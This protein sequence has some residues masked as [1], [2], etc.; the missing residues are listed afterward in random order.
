MAFEH[1]REPLA[2]R[3]HFAWRQFKFATFAVLFLTLS[4]LLGMAGYHW[5]AGLAWI[6]ALLDASMIL[7]GMGPVSPL[8][9]DGAK[10]FASAYALFSGIAFLTT[11]SV[12]I[13]PVVHRIM[14]QLHL[15]ADKS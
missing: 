14:H 11:F 7:T 13:A 2:T 8:P 4:L 6:D 3:H 5:L 12:L 15:K 1:H 10:I 9:T